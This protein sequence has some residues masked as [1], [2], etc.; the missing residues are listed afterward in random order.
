MKNLSFIVLT[1]NSEK[2][3]RAC[4]E[5]II[6]SCV[7]ESISYEV[8]VVDN[9]SS[10][11]SIS[12]VQEFMELQPDNFTL[13]ALG[14]NRGTTYPRNLGL[15][16]AVGE[17]ICILDSD[18]ELGEGSLKNVLMCLATQH[19]VG[20]LAPRLLL[21]DGSVQNSVK[22]FPTMLDKLM[23]VPR[24]VS[25][26]KTQN[27]DF[28]QEFPFKTERNVDTA[29]SACWFIR[30]KHW[31]NIGDLD[32]MIFY[33]PEDLDYSIRVWK[34]GF[35]VL[36]YPLFTVLHHT[37]QITHRKPL[38]KTSLS[39]FRGLLYYYWKHGGWMIRPR[40]ELVTRI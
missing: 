7:R 13:L 36:Y 30:K 33:A 2:Y 14:S 6:S 3:L 23:K 37:Q 27:T 24:I 17:Y 10:D 21:P 25:N 15:K 20:I 12:L 5:S 31:E 19:D 11:G 38:S 29:I 26:I 32:E 18:T 40:Y 16:K 28:Y 1:W 9:G 8:I 22:R 34:A 35:R 39:H 4:F